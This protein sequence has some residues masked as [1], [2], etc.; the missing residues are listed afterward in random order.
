MGL[1]FGF[2]FALGASAFLGWGL[3]CVLPRPRRVL[4]FMLREYYYPFSFCYYA[5]AATIGCTILSHF[6]QTLYM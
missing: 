4:V 6:V 3:S 2:G 1:G 5:R